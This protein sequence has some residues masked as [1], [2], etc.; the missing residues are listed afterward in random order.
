MYDIAFK[1]SVNVLWVILKCRTQAKSSQCLWLSL[2]YIKKF[3][4]MCWLISAGIE[5]RALC[6]L[7]KHSLMEPN[8]Q[9]QHLASLLNLF[10]S[11][12]V[13]INFNYWKSMCRCICLVVR[14]CMWMQGFKESR[15]GNQIPL[16]KSYRQLWTTLGTKLRFLTG[17]VS[18]P[19]LLFA[20]YML[21]K[22]WILCGVFH[23]PHL[24]IV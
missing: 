13:K 21:L 20:L 11:L 10:H 23:V 9:P 4:V 7:S 14:M 5:P 2:S 16:K 6:L 3:L 8:S 22:R 15:R 17:A 18:T 12:H 19:A 1:F 24:L